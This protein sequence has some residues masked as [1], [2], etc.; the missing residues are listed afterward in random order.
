MSH[1]CR[2]VG[3]DLHL[4]NRFRKFKTSCVKSS[5]SSFE[6]R[7][8]GDLVQ[9]CKLLGGGGGGSMLVA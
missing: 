8:E 2:G 6:Q 1:S 3:H 9:F 5:M 7:T 4:E